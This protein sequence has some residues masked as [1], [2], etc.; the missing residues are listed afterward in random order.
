MSEDLETAGTAARWRARVVG[1]FAPGARRRR[2]VGVLAALVVVAV[3]VPVVLAA[4]DGDE[5][6]GP[7]AGAFAR[8]RVP[9]GQK[10]TSIPP[11]C[12]VTERTVGQLTG[13]EDV[14]EM[15]SDADSQ[16]C[17]WGTGSSASSIGGS[18][19]ELEVEVEK[20]HE[21]AGSGPGVAAAMDEFARRV[22]DES[23]SSAGIK[24]G[25]VRALTGLG[26]EA[27]AWPRLDTEGVVYP[28]G[29]ITGVTGHTRYTTVL[30]REGNLVAQVTFGGADYTSAGRWPGERKPKE[31]LLSED[32]TFAG[33]VRAA[34]D[35]AASMGL[36][37]DAPEVTRS[38]DRKLAEFPAAC[39]LLP[40][41]TVREL[42]LSGEGDVEDSYLLDD[43][44]SVA[45][46]GC[47]WD[48]D[49]EVE[50]VAVPT[51]RLGTGEERAA[52]RFGYLY[53]SA[54]EH[55]PEEEDDETFFRALT[56][57][58]DEAFV[59]WVKDTSSE[60]TVVFRK[61]DVLVRISARDIDTETYSRDEAMNDAYTAALAAAKRLR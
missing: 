33:A 16:T 36:R 47:D 54:R 8:D 50:I 3:A 31:R 61:R 17:T 9:V 32:Q 39:D 21:L 59:G 20:S 38:R 10:V 6:A 43:S 4:V 41:A 42:G 34:R 44:A 23:K 45:G 19:R 57:P 40:R 26:H 12:G 60:A 49:L 11:F 48:Y 29:K 46:K 51:N 27:V 52:R 56:G 15:I 13:H 37:E 5:A 53:Q 24:S 1:Q 55:R 18:N 30:F 58:G 22:L 25:D 28:G 14:Q 2:A 35:V 7:V